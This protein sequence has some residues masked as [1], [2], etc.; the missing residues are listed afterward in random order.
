MSVV[1]ESDD[2]AAVPG[3]VTS[4]APSAGSEVTDQQPGRAMDSSGESV[5]TVTEPTGESGR[6]P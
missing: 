5:R 2:P 6:S 3:D 4:A 1:S